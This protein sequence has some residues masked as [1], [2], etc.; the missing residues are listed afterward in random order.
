MILTNNEQFEQ[1]IEFYSKKKNLS[2]EEVHNIFFD[3]IMHDTDKDILYSVFDDI[4][5]TYTT[6]GMFTYVDCRLIH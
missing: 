3:K 5:F 6:E 1:V 2:K 4:F